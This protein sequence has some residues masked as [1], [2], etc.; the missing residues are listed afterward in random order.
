MAADSQSGE[1]SI[2]MLINNVEE[3]DSGKGKIHKTDDTKL[4]ETV[5]KNT[6]PQ[7]F[8]TYFLGPSLLARGLHK[9]AVVDMTSTYADYDNKRIPV[10]SAS[11]A[12][13]AQ[14]SEVFGLEYE[15]QLDILTVKAEPVKSKRFP[16]GVDA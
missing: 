2:S 10:Y 4:L 16:G 11:K 7:V 12:L 6:F 3:F 15:D 9:A 14:Q 5:N 8:M 1:N 13:Q